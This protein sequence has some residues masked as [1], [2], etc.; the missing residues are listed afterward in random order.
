MGVALWLVVATVFA[1]EKTAAAEVDAVDPTALV[2]GD[3]RCPTPTLVWQRLVP[4][5]P[6]EVL[7]DR[8]RVLGGPTPPVQ[9]VDLDT[10]FRVLAGH[11]VRE[12]QD[13]TRD[14]AKRERCAAISP[15][16]AVVRG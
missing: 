7:A 11:R 2:G 1:A 16:H 10:S 6:S 9:I 15:A 13:E 14:C 8:L 4:L 5:V 3:S 12:F